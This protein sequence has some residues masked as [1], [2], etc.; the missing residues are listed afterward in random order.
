[1]VWV[2]Y[3]RLVRHQSIS[4]YRECKGPQCCNLD[5]LKLVKRVSAAPLQSSKLQNPLEVTSI[6]KGN[7]HR[8]D[9]YL[10]LFKN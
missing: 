5:K 1:M 6:S 7:L 2:K 10:R 4:F 8:M 9:Y 3:E